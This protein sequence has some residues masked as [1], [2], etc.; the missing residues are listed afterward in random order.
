MESGGVTEDVQSYLQQH[1]CLYFWIIPMTTVCWLAE[2]QVQTATMAM[3][4]VSKLY[5]GTYTRDMVAFANPLQC[6]CSRVMH[7]RLK[8]G[9]E[10]EFQVACRYLL[11]QIQPSGCNLCVDRMYHNIIIHRPDTITQSFMIIIR[12]WDD[13]FNNLCTVLSPVLT[14]CRAS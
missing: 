2:F 11:Y 4:L 6:W 3:V 7:G 14:Y 10:E 12:S 5:A 9:D 13:K 8:P 1:V